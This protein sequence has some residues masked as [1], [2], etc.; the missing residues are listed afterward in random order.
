[1]LGEIVHFEIIGNDQNRLEGFYKDIFQWEITPVMDGYSL[2]KPSRGINGGIG[3]RGIFQHS[4]TF[5]IHVP[6]IEET[7]AAV[8]SNGGKR[9][10]GPFPIPDGSQIAGFTDPEGNLIGLVQAAP[11]M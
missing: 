1:M 8:E 3:A 10:F 7:F 6:N 11:G 9:A 5:Y 2:V 4:V